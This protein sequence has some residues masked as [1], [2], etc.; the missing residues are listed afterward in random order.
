MLQNRPLCYPEPSHLTHSGI[1]ISKFAQKY[2]KNL[3]KFSKT[4]LGFHDTIH[5]VKTPNTYSFT[6]PPKMKYLLLEG[7]GVKTPVLLL[8]ASDILKLYRTDVRKCLYRTWY[9]WYTNRKFAADIVLPV[10][11]GF[12]WIILFYILNINL[13]GISPGQ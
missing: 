1:E 2:F 10:I 9:H 5:I 6:T 11:R 3:L 4:D 7:I 13:P 12:Q 8:Y